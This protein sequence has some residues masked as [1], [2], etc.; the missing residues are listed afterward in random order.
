[1]LDLVI[2]SVSNLPPLTMSMGRT[3]STTMRMLALMAG[4][5]YI[6]QMRSSVPRASDLLQMELFFTQPPEKA[7]S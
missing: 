2:K 7:I 3:F 6:V 4:R 1:L 5:P